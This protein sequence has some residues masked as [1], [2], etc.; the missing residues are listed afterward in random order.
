MIETKNLLTVKE[1]SDWATNFLGKSVTPSNIASLINYGRVNKIGENG[2]VFVA[3]RYLID[4]Y[5]TYQRER[6]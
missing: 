2:N 1:A 5:E 3:K 4:Y 6:V